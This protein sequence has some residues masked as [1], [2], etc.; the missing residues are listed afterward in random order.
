MNLRRLTLVL[1]AV[2]G[3]LL[4]ACGGA[5]DP[6][7]TAEV[8]PIE[9]DSASAGNVTIYRI[10]SD[11]SQ[12]RF[13]LD[14]VLRGQDKTVVGITD[15]V[16]GEIA[17]D[18][19]DLST[20]QVGTIIVSAAGLETDN[21]FRNRAIQ[22]FILQTGQYPE[23]TFSPTAIDDL[24]DG[25]QAGETINFTISGDLAIRDQTRTVTFSVSATLESNGRLVGTA[26]TSVARGDF[27]LQ[28]PDAPGVANV[29]ETV[30]L[31]IDFIAT[32]IS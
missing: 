32:A 18:P 23:I 5:G 21:G 22:N 7:A 20:A 29:E 10:S 24:P 14:E 3:L 12:V 19:G 16:A 11:E 15:Q 1:A 25:A 4:A 28:I 13:E 26:S 31:Y 2:V 9:V 6:E 27:G 30:E 17:L 8:V